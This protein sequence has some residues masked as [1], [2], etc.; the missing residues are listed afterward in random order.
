MVGFPR[1]LSQTVRAVRDHEGG[2]AQPLHGGYIPHQLQLLNI[3]IRHTE[4]QLGIQSAPNCGSGHPGSGTDAHVFHLPQSVVGN[5]SGV[6]AVFLL[7]IFADILV[8]NLIKIPWGRARMRLV[9]VDDRAYFMLYTLLA[10]SFVSHL[11][12]TPTP[13]SFQE[14]GA[15]FSGLPHSVSETVP[16]LGFQ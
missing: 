6:A 15:V 13:D 3:Q 8:V 5:A 9:A 11:N 14:P 12:D 2:H 4:R 1:L 7:V 10:C 16:T